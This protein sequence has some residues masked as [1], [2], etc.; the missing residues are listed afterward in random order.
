MARPRTRTRVHDAVLALAREERLAHITM[1]GVA[2][3]AGVSKQTLYRSW[4]ST[5]AILFDALLVRSQGADGLVIVPD[6]GDLAADLRTLVTAT[7]VEL[8]D[9]TMEPLLR[10]VTAD[11]QTDDVLAAAFRDRL[12]MPQLQAITDRLVRGGID[13]SDA[14][15][16][17]LGPIL[18]RWLL[19]ARDFDARW[20]DRHVERVLRAVAPVEGAGDRRRQVR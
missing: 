11:I 1:E 17:L 9:P 6:T 14:A 5:G 20:A 18:H 7:V 19:R 4:P 3:R 12:L 8:T 16:L 2:A 10:A 15:E 13:D